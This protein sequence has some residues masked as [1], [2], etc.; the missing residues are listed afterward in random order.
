M[1][2]HWN[3]VVL[4]AQVLVALLSI[5]FLTPLLDVDVVKSN[6]GDSIA[7]AAQIGRLDIVS[8]I[9]A[10]MGIM[11]ALFAFA[12]Y[13]SIRAHAEQ[14]AKSEARYISEEIAAKTATQE[15]K[16]IIDNMLPNDP[17]VHDSVYTNDVNTNESK[18]VVSKDD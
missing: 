16:R 17:I 15:T 12:G 4:V 1:K 2:I 13:F 8:L 3:V 11:L 14:V 5:L 7:V 18:Q 10:M 9:F 6:E